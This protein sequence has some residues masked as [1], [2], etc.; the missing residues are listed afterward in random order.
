[1]LLRVDVPG[2]RLQYSWPINLLSFWLLDCDGRLTEEFGVLRAGCALAASECCFT[3][4]FMHGCAGHVTAGSC[5]AEC[6]GQCSAF[7]ANDSELLRNP[8]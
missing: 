1:M 3:D 7:I 4:D 6:G 5:S 8:I 2:W